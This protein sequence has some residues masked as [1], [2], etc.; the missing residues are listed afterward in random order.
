MC[1]RAGNKTVTV[2]ELLQ[3][4][5]A[6]TLT[7]IHTYNIKRLNIRVVNLVIIVLRLSPSSLSLNRSIFDLSLPEVAN[8][9]SLR[10]PNVDYLFG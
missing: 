10:N 1:N 9:D 3:G 4:N 2:T 6:N 8:S 5:Y 7:Y